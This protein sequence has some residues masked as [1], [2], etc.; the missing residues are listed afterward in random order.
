MNP[1]ARSELIGELEHMQKHGNSLSMLVMTVRTTSNG[2]TAGING[3]V[4]SLDYPRAGWLDFSRAKRFESFCKQQGF[5]THK[6][7]WG[8]ERIIRAA[9]G[10]SAIDAA[11][12]IDACF[13]AVYG[14]S[15]AFGLQLRGFGW[16]PSS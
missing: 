9:I 6:E 8:K 4:F 3:G 14:E 10:S 12:A 13:C 1:S 16:Q 7:K 15:G 2:L 5:P 11:A